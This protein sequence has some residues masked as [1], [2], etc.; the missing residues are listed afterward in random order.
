[1]IF[2]DGSSNGHALKEMRRKKIRPVTNFFF[3]FNLFFSFT[4]IVHEHTCTDQHE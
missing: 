2:A 1:M 3:A 4:C